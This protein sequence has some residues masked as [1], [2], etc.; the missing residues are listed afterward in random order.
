MMDDL[1]ELLA[2]ANMFASTCSRQQEKYRD[3][4]DTA[5]HGAGKTARRPT[6]SCVNCPTIGRWSK[7]G[8]RNIYAERVGFRR[9]RMQCGVRSGESE[10]NSHA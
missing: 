4:S 6:P 10:R 7:R 3:F 9:T 8:A 2:M 5:T 1:Q